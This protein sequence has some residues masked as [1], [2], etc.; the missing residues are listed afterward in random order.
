METPMDKTMDTIPS[1]TPEVCGKVPGKLKGVC[2]QCLDVDTYTVDK[3]IEEYQVAAGNYTGENAK[4][5]CMLAAAQNGQMPSS[6]ARPAR[7]QTQK[8]DAH[9]QQLQMM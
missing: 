9:L 1:I 8:V 5:A 4:K 6:Q 2:E 3:P 7:K